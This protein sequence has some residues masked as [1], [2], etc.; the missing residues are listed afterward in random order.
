M[1]G[2]L[3]FFFIIILS[4]FFFKTFDFLCTSV[5]LAVCAGT[6]SQSFGREVLLTAELS[7]AEPLL[8]DS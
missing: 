5:L 4:S 2:S 3:V 7:R 6:Q 8:Q 1:G